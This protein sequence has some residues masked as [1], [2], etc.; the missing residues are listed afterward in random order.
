MRI[1]RGA[2]WYLNRDFFKLFVIS[3]ELG[4]NEYRGKRETLYGLLNGFA[5]SA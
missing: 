3:I 5:K 1:V 2:G 4:G